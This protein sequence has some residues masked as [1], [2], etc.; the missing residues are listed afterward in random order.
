MD[1]TNLILGMP[2]LIEF[3][4]LEENAEFCN[5]LGL[6]FIEIN[7]NLPQHQPSKLNIENLLSIQKNKNIFFTFHLPEDI[8]IAHLNDKIR[9]VHWDIIMEVIDI[10]KVIKSPLINMHI[11]EGIHFKLPDRRIFLYEKYIDEYIDMMNEFRKTAD[12]Q[13]KGS[14]IKI[15]IENMGIYDR[16]FTRKAVSKLLESDVFGLTWD[17]GHDYSSGEK[18]RDFI[19]ANFSKLVHMHIHDAKE[20]R[21]HLVLYSGNMNIDDRLELARSESITSVIETKTV[22]GLR[23]S[24]TELRNRGYIL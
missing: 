9:K 4:S 13:L 12:E 11:L 10:M 19:I 8:N 1:K 17:I 23:T 22:E 5:E 2:T 7:M 14:S 16:G 3:D 20:Q 24:V 18:D 6:D 15:A 21:C